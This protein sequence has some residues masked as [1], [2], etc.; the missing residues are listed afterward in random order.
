MT[1][2]VRPASF[3][4]GTLTLL[5]ALYFAQG[6]PFGFF[7]QALPVVLR[8]SGFSLVKISAT[9]V[10][11]LPWALKF[12]W[13]PYVD[14]YG[15]RRRWLLSLQCSAAAVALALSFLDLSSTLRWLF[16]GIFVMNALSATQDIATDG[17]AV[18]TLTAAQRGLG[19]GLQVGAY[20]IGMV[21]GGGLLLWLFT[22]AGWRA[23]FV[24]MALLI[25]LT[26]LPVWWMRRQ[27]DAADA[28]SDPHAERPRPGRLAGAWWSRL[29]RPGMI[30]F[31]L[32]IIGFKFGN[33]MG[34]ALVG[35]FLSDSG[36]SLPQIA[37]VEGGLSSVAAVGG[38]ALGAWLAFRYGRR[39][40]LLVGGVSQTLSL[41]LYVVAS[42]GVGGFPLLVTANIT[43]HVLGGA[44]TV[45]VFALMMDA[46]EKRFAGSDYTLMACAIV[47]AQ[48]AAGIAAGVVGDL[49]GYTAM[50]GSAL[51]L[52]GIGCVLLLLAL[53]RGCGPEGLRQVIPPK[54]VVV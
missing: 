31:I 38:A 32:L 5:G 2:A 53:D 29:R 34:S 42:L 54:T 12:L 49:F 39:R 7:T 30:A 14:R 44:A 48:G 47:F 8:E 4:A 16:V 22:F 11:F 40:A 19:N 3:T 23:L 24:A 35:P 43:E 15:S 41:A 20:R 33:S 50:F 13:A 1:N 17:I 45:A 46:S 25:V 52:S 51:V 37:L 21:C 9:G 10:L 26:T 6:V 36:L 27:L 28:D 18:R